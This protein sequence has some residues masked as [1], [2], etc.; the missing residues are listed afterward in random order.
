MWTIST[1]ADRETWTKVEDFTGTH[2]EA[3]QRMLV[4]QA[5][6]PGLYS[7]QPAASQAAPAAGAAA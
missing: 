1:T 7:V 4:L 2:D 3:L 5:K 6:T